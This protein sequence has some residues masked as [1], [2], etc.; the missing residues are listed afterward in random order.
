M[1]AC[2]RRTE[3]TGSLVPLDEHKL[4][5][6]IGKWTHFIWV[7][8]RSVNMNLW[9]YCL[10][11][12]WIADEYDPQVGIRTSMSLAVVQMFLAHE[13]IDQDLES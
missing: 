5:S 9:M 4:Y 3:N 8:D 11:V 6:V 2:V 1:S 12:L 13:V 10:Y 7:D